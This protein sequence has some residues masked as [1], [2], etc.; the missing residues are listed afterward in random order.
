MEIIRPDTHIG[1]VSKMKRAGF[2]S[3]VLLAVAIVSL[4]L[5]KGPNWGVEFVGG[6]ELQIKL[7]QKIKRSLSHP[8]LPA[9][10]FRASQLARVLLWT[11]VAI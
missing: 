7:S 6:T 10:R 1:F 8:E 5:H 9:L 3:I 11:L 2:V 4:I